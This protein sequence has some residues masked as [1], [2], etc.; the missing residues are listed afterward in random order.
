[1]R[2]RIAGYEYATDRLAAEAPS[3]ARR[4][5]QKAIRS[6]ERTLGGPSATRI[7]APLVIRAD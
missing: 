6:L 1:L 7:A 3:P 4:D 2:N 5:A